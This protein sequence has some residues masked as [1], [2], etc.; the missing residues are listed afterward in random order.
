LGYTPPMSFMGDFIC[1]KYPKSGGNKGESNEFV[2]ISLRKP[3][4]II[5]FQSYLDRNL[6]FDT[7][8]QEALYLDPAA[9]EPL[10]QWEEEK[11]RQEDCPVY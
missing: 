10:A 1:R 3:Q 6:L 11:V 9:P 5:F 4:S 2:K 8:I 7:D